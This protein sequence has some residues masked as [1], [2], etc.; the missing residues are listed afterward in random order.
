MVQTTVSNFHIYFP[1]ITKFQYEDAE[2][3]WYGATSMN[4]EFLPFV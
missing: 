4:L 3:F 1:A 2:N